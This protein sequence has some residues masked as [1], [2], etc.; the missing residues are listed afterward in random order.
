MAKNTPVATPVFN[1][2]D[3]T[4]EQK[5]A[6]FREH[7]RDLYVTRRATELGVSEEKVREGLRDRDPNA[8]KRT[9]VSVTIPVDLSPEKQLKRIERGLAALTAAKES[10]TAAMATAAK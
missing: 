9:L 2:A 6:I 3:L 5:L 8:P 7:Q 1:M 10:V 4:A